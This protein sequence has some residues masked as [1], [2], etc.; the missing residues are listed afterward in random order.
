MNFLV[1]F[2]RGVTSLTGG[3]ITLG[4]VALTLFLLGRERTVPML[5]GVLRAMVTWLIAPFGYLRRLALEV[6]EFGEHLKTPREHRTLYLLERFVACQQ[7]GL[8]IVAALI[9]GTGAA[10]AWY[11]LLPD[12]GLL[13]DLKETRSQTVSLRAE[14]EAKE[15]EEQQSGALREQ[16][17][18]DALGIYRSERQ[19]I[20]DRSASEMTRLAGELRGNPETRVLL[21][22]LEGEIAKDP[23]A[24]LN[25]V[26][27][28]HRRLANRMEGA[29]WAG[30]DQGPLGLWLAAWKAKATAELELA[31]ADSTVRAEYARATAKLPQEIKSLRSRLEPLE[32]RLSR[33]E[34]ENRPQWSRAAKSLGTTFATLMVTLWLAGLLLELL[35][36]WIG[37]AGDVR[38]LRSSLASG[39]NPTEHLHNLRPP[40]L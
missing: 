38:D 13:E 28:L 24:D 9:L 5:L 29:T 14:L 16:R 33:L 35:G 23:P 40:S 30:G 26:S 39:E 27:R 31:R 12:P 18:A 32:A 8:L 1:S 10:G 17:I 20:V 37:V 25:A 3:A 2:L 36:S 15:A 19:P 7:A 4:V 22:F 21:D 11:A 34:S 6:A